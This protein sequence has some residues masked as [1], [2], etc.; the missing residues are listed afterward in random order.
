MF[1][2]KVSCDLWLCRYFR[3]KEWGYKVVDI[4]G[5]KDFSE[6]KRGYFRLFFM[7]RE[8]GW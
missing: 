1:F 5:Y 4:Y 6:V 8:C 3:L 7:E 2:Y